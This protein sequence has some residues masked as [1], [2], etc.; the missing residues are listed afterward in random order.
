MGLSDDSRA[1]DNRKK[2][3]MIRNLGLA[4][5]VLALLGAG[6]LY[7]QKVEQQKQVALEARQL[8]EQQAAANERARFEAEQRARAEAAARQRAEEE[9]AAR[10]AAAEAARIRAEEAAQAIRAER[11][12]LLHTRGSVRITSIPSGAKV[13]IPNRDSKL[14]P[15][16][17][18]DLRL[19]QYNAT[20]E[21]DGFDSATIK[22]AIDGEEL[23]EPSAVRLIRHTGKLEITTKPVGV[24]FEIRPASPGPFTSAM[25]SRI[26]ITPHTFGTLPTDDYIV[27]L[28]PEGLPDVSRAVTIEHDATTT[29]FENLVG[30]VVRITSN[31]SGASV[32]GEDDTLLGVTPLEL[33]VAAGEASFRVEHPEYDPTILT[34]HVELGG[35]TALAA[36]LEPIAK[37]ARISELDRKP[38]PTRRIEPDLDDPK[39]YAGFNA[40]ISLIVN[41]EGRPESVEID[42][43]TDPEFGQLCAAAVRQWEFKPGR[44]GRTPVRTKVK[45]PFKIR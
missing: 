22:F 30:G 27:T 1:A 5:G 20:L 12:R 41:E 21:L 28:K 37:L 38:T 31:P 40:I 39:N 44:I 16:D 4:A 17:F 9:M 19:G 35:V 7:F 32:F 2:S 6:Y 13:T 15:A 43:A 18:S 29:L 8:A 3:Q 42:E 26:G 24:P 45:I 33:D 14:S 23:T 11:E 10:T 36:T 34:A 25:Q